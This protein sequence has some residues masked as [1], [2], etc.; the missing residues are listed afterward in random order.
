MRVLSP[1]GERRRFA[2]KKLDPSARGRTIGLVNNGFGD[3]I[4]TTFF[5]RLQ[6]LFS[7]EPGVT[8]VQVWR[9][10]VFTRPSPEKLIDE[11]A[12]AA[13]QAVVGLCA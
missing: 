5:A 7:A 9:K 10:P 2:E 4:A 12:T 13:H 8:E 11:V 1:V 3:K 6:E